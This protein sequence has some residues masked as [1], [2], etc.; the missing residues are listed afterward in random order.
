MRSVDGQL[1]GAKKVIYSRDHILRRKNLTK[2]IEEG[3]VKS[4]QKM[5]HMS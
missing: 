3:N 5:E 4:R 2:V 1:I